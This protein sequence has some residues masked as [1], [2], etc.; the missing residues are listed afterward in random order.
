MKNNLK[1]EQWKR[2][3]MG[4]EEPKMGDCVLSYAYVFLVID[5]E[6]NGISINQNRNPPGSRW[7][8]PIVARFGKFSKKRF[9][10]KI[11]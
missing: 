10:K 4:Y 7:V 5:N 2:I 11:I 8:E 9:F 1:N 6:L 3:F